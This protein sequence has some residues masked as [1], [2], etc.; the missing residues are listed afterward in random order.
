[1]SQL[2]HVKQSVGSSPPDLCSDD[3]TLHKVEDS[4]S[5]PSISDS[6]N[7]HASKDHS[8]IPYFLLH[9]NSKVKQGQSQ[10]RIKQR[11]NIQITKNCLDQV[12]DLFKESVSLLFC[13]ESGTL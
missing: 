1:M 8:D 9:D 13:G 3:M 11:A 2:C 5:L 6:L 7:L 12:A 4:P 10:L